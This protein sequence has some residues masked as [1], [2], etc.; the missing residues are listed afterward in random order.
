MK[1][2][3]WI[4][5]VQ[6]F[7]RNAG[8]ARLPDFLIEEQPLHHEIVAINAGQIGSEPPLF[9]SKEKVTSADLEQNAQCGPRALRGDIM[10][11]SRAIYWI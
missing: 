2:R 10:E 4:P 6:L 5:S 11:S 9:V 7:H 1:A 8:L 3:R